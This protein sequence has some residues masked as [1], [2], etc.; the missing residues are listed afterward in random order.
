MPSLPPD[1]F[2]DTA[3]GLNAR[4]IKHEFTAHELARAFCDRLEKIGP[5]F[6][7]LALLLRGPALKKAALADA[8]L[9]RERLRGPLQGVPFG[10]KDLLSAAGFP[11]TW[12]A[13]PFRSQ[14]FADDAT[15]LR[16]LAGSGAV[17][18]A[19]LSMVELA[20]G[21][22]YRFA[23]ASLTGP[24][25]NPWDPTR[26]SGGSSSGS[27]AAVAAGLAPFALGS[28]TWGSIGVPCAFCGVTGLRPTYGLV[29]RTGAMA[30]SWSMDKIGPIARTA[31]DCAHILQVIAGGDMDDPGSAGRS[32]HFLPQTGPPLTGMTAGYA[33]ADFD[34]SP[35]P[36]LRSALRD[37]LG[38]FRDTGLQLKEADGR[39]DH[40]RRR[41]YR[42]RRSDR[43]RRRR[44]IGRPAPD[45][46]P[47]GRPRNP[48][49]RLPAGHAAAPPVAGQ[50]G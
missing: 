29:S 17:L 34:S 22:G 24:G 37:A 36:A 1:V 27:A 2:F 19:K 8:E 10:A 35:Q 28:E 26:W 11:T 45:R 23:S 16:R 25:L 30:L 48:R 3:S 43:V 18:C 49:P 6:N 31:E 39:A 46:R 5:R 33:S 44:T 9:K 42:L 13:R 38:V 7:A 32:F 50:Y 40:R 47:P 4:W 15:V 21:G 20:G 41:R 12:G 14:V